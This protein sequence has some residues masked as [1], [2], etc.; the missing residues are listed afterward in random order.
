[1]FILFIAG[2]AQCEPQTK[3][4]I[5]VRRTPSPPE[6]M[7][8]EE[9]PFKILCESY[10]RTKGREN[11]ELFQID[12]DGS[13]LINLTNTPDLHEMYPH[14]SP[15]G[16]KICFVADEGIGRRRLRNVYYM[17]IDGTERV[18]IA[19]NARQPCWSPDGKT[20]AY[21]KGEYDRYSTREYAT[22][23]LF[24]YE[25]ETRQHRPHVN[26]T[27]HHVYAINWSPDGNWFLG[28]VH[29]GMTYSDTILAFEVKGTR[30]F[31]L[32]RWGVIGCRPDIS[33][34]GTKMVWGE[35]D[36]D[37][38]MADIDLTGR[39]PRVSNVHKVVGCRR[40]ETEKVYHVDLSPDMKY[41]VFTH[42]PWSGGQEVGGKAK[43][44]NLCISD[45]SGK[46][47]RIT[48]DGLHYKEPDWIPIP[49]KKQ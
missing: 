30:V 17:N 1:M 13:N 2:A 36:W 33:V 3:N 29:G 47:V 15:D 38:C 18:K 8:L 11:W 41:I 16:T 49:S 39:S 24:F 10:R 32:A 37:L 35:V 31:D 42:G 12:A 14:A 26:K 5:R 44:W 4:R 27:L 45:L 28:V 22:S 46:W 34:D 25:I 40:F 9:I 7:N 20:I 23:E 19:R 21:L 6:E 43:G 48:T